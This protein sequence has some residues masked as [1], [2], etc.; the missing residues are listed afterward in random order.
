MN[1]TADP[2]RTS[3]PPSRPLT[4]PPWLPLARRAPYLT[5]PLTGNFIESHKDDDWFLCFAHEIT[6]SSD[7]LSVSQ[8]KMFAKLYCFF[9]DHL[10]RGLTGQH[11]LVL[12]ADIMAYMLDGTGETKPSKHRFYHHIW[13]TA[14]ARL[15][16][17]MANATHWEEALRKARE[18]DGKTDPQGQASW[19]APGL[20]PRA[21]VLA[22]LA[23]AHPD[24]KVIRRINDL[25]I[26]WMLLP[27]STL[28]V[29]EGFWKGINSKNLLT[30]FSA[31]DNH[32]A[33]VFLF[34]DYSQLFGENFQRCRRDI[35]PFL[36]A[37]AKTR[38]LPCISQGSP[39]TD[40]DDAGSDHSNRTLDRVN[41]PLGVL[42]RLFTS[43][44][45]NDPGLL[46]W[47]EQQLSLEASDVLRSWRNHWAQRL[48]AV[49]D[50]REQ[51]IIWSLFQ[52]SLGRLMNLYPRGSI[53]E[54]TPEAYMLLD[55]EDSR[56][57]QK[58]YITTDVPQLQKVHRLLACQEATSELGRL[59]RANKTAGSLMADVSS[60]KAGFYFEMMKNPLSTR[61]AIDAM[62]FDELRIRALLQD[63]QEHSLPQDEPW[64][65]H[66][67]DTVK[68]AQLQLTT[69]QQQMLLIPGQLHNVLTEQQQ[70]IYFSVEPNQQAVCEPSVLIRT[71]PR[72]S[73][74]R[75]K[76]ISHL[77][78][79]LSGTISP[80]SASLAP[81]PQ[82]SPLTPARS[83][84]AAFQARS[85]A[86][87]PTRASIPGSLT[88]TL[89][90]PSP[91]RR[92]P[93][94]VITMQDTD[95]LVM[96]D[97]P[98]ASPAPQS[99]EPV[100]HG[101]SSGA[102]RPSLPG[103]LLQSRVPETREAADG[104]DFFS[105]MISRERSPMVSVT[106]P[107]PLQPVGQDTADA[108]GVEPPTP[109]AEDAEDFF[110]DFT[111]L[112]SYHAQK[113]AGSCVD[114]GAPK[115]PRVGDVARQ[116]EVEELRVDIKALKRYTKAKIK[117][118]MKSLRATF[119]SDINA[120][121][122]E[123]LGAFQDH[124][125]QVSVQLQEALEGVLRQF[126]DK[127]DAATRDTSRQAIRTEVEATRV[128]METLKA[129]Q[130]S[131]QQSMDEAA[132]QQAAMKTEIEALKSALEKTPGPGEDGY[133]SRHCLAP[134]GWSDDQKTYESMC[135][136]AAMAYVSHLGMPSDNF[137]ANQDAFLATKHAFPEVSPRQ[138]TAALKH[139]HVLM[140]NQPFMRGSE[141]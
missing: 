23:I 55:I 30:C 16:E 83:E 43:D 91:L 64:P 108:A 50:A 130:E 47:L 92:A 36:P 69:W 79:G 98:T 135:F 14:W 100:L 27:R 39:E 57:G 8:G 38:G 25:Q 13:Y 87:H 5:Q 53:P 120:A 125:S 122:G 56:K 73:D 7:N 32:E 111:E 24:R 84:Q 137:H 134:A 68:L 71:T 45:A 31:C 113:R 42:R 81:T 62:S 136:R 26:S 46:E 119:H 105:E 131:S 99:T 121:R 18:G 15:E 48:E 132:I 123:M 35:R 114:R 10:P 90:R 54:I 6:T 138:L 41:N 78:R 33:E 34:A 20:L 140:Y 76:A 117:A 129:A 97:R 80:P 85:S 11:E 59:T 104:E 74:Q 58:E 67:R 28:S 82:M 96:A 22:L 9:L 94:A 95:D 133:L 101:W 75:D 72:P 88:P 21:A 2:V 103:E 60:H 106:A 107:A 102:G 29:Q 4:D 141:A 3:R 86:P 63:L 109:G 112:E 37:W 66:Q 118:T 70:R 61:H 49:A 124:A 89:L 128:E 115:R 1:G 93:P 139:L 44:C 19:K 52:Q 77:L 127:L 110:A 12:G 17:W 126:S 40:D 116:E 65:E 51:V